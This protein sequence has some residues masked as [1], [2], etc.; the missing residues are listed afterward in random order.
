MQN[1]FLKL[2][3]PCTE[4]WEDMVPNKKGNYCNLCAKNV[5]DFTGLSHFE[6][7]QEM[8]LANGNICARV[9][10]EQLNAPFFELENHT[11]NSNCFPYSKIAAGII[12][13][14][15]FVVS[16]PILAKEYKIE[17]KIEQAF[18]TNLKSKNKKRPINNTTSNALFTIVKGKVVSEKESLPIQNAKI[19][20]VTSQKIWITHTLKDGTFSMQVPTE[21]IDDDNVMRISFDKV[22]YKNKEDYFFGFETE[23][24]VLTKKEINSIISIQARPL[25]IVMGGISSYSEKPREPLVVKNGIQIPF[26]EFIK[27]RSDMQKYIYFSSKSAIAL[28]GKKA[29]YGLYLSVEV[30]E[31]N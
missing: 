16:Q 3:K 25:N 22:E 8:K 18:T 31:T 28:C 10:S 13:A 11:K 4:N 19:T 6:I 7:A 23:D 21:F 14:S 30:I 26:K 20:F 1:K 17:N 15:S 2:E 29:Q 12:L 9:T 27:D 5:I 24:L